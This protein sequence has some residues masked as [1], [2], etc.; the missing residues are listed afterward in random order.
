MNVGSKDS[1]LPQLSPGVENCSWP[2]GASLPRRLQPRKPAAKAWSR[3]G[4]GNQSTLQLCPE[5]STLSPPD[6]AKIGVT[7]NFPL[8]GSSLTALLAPPSRVSSFQ[9]TL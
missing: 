8:G 1:Q 3:K 9:K 6:Q 2:T 4:K 7:G 5:P